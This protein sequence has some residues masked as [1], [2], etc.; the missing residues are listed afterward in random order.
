MC[1]WIGGLNIVK[2]STVPKAMYRLNTMLVKMPVG[3]FFFFLQ[4]YKKQPPSSLGV[5]KYPE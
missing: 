2:M 3:F 1:S 4:K 5:A